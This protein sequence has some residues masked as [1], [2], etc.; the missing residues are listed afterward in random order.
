MNKIY[1]TRYSYQTRTSEFSKLLEGEDFNAFISTKGLLFLSSSCLASLKQHKCWERGKGYYLSPLEERTL[2]PTG[3]LISLIHDKQ[4]STGTS[5]TGVTDAWTETWK[6]ENMERVKTANH[7]AT[8]PAD[9]VALVENLA[10]E[11][12]K[13]NNALGMLGMLK[14]PE[15][16]PNK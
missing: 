8:H 2:V 13:N 10:M 5:T 7:I 12:V 9:V 14:E 4:N 6:R 16:D 1:L 15:F 3:H 11:A